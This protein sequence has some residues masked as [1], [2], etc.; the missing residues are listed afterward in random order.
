LQRAV[1]L[2]LQW[3]SWALSRFDE[4]DISEES[5]LALQESLAAQEA[6]LKETSLP[7]SLREMLE[8]QVAD[9]KTALL[10]Y[11]VSGTKPLIDAVNRQYGEIRQSF[12][13]IVEFAESG[14]PEADTLMRKALKLLGEAANVANQGSKVI[15]FGKDICE[16]GAPGMRIGQQMWTAIETTIQAIKQG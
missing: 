14:P 12:A 2:E 10:L 7:E 16:L 6:M 4:N 9:L 15:K 11:E 13:E 3:A 8:R 1:P 5:I